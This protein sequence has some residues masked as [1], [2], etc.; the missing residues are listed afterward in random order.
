MRDWIGDS[1]A[2][3]GI[4]KSLGIL[5]GLLLWYA[6]LPELGL[7]EA[8]DRH[9]R[10]GVEALTIVG[11]AWLLIALWDSTSDRL[12]ARAGQVDHRAEKLLVPVIGKLVRAAILT[13]A[14]VVALG[15]FGVNVLGLLAG[16]GIGG[17]VLALAAKDSVEN[18]LG[19]LTL[20]FDMPFSIGD[21]VKIGTIEGTVEEIN[22]RSTRIRAP[23]DGLIT[24][25]NSN[26]VRTSVENLSARIGRRQRFHLRLSS[27]TPPEKLELFLARLRAYMAKNSPALPD[28]S[29]VELDDLS[30]GS[31]G[32]LVQCFFA[33]ETYAEEMRLRND[34]L[35]EILRMTRD[36]GV[37]MAQ[38]GAAMPPEQV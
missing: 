3:T 12:A 26:L 14:I 2:F 21:L 24:L 4:K 10:Y 17:L 25:P 22:L 35:L 11:I 9:V 8:A 5:A 23:D 13:V 20:I 32:V 38:I 34:L 37:Q 1:N 28:R 27:D 7:S 16:I 31:L 33:A 19:S 18:V 36:T 15:V 30:V 6:A 29:I